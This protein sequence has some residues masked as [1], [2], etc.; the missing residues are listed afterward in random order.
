MLEEELRE[1]KHTL[2]AATRERS[3]ASKVRGYAPVHD[4]SAPS[5]SGTCGDAHSSIE[6]TPARTAGLV[7]GFASVAVSEDNARRLHSLIEEK[8]V[9]LG[10]TAPQ[11][12]VDVDSL[13]RLRKREPG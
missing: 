12:I 1:S 10:E 13:P 5:T 11:V 2:S 7:V 4:S 6:L 8:Q 9:P 3:H